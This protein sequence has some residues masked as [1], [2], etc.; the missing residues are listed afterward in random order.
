M[1]WAGAVSL[2]A[3]DEMTIVERLAH[4]HLSYIY[5]SGDLNKGGLD[6]SGFVQVVFREAYGL[7][8]PDEAD[9]QLGYCREHGQVWDAT[10]GWTPATLRP[11]DLIFFAGPDV[12]PR[13]SDV[14]HVMIYC[15]GNIMA[16]AQG[17]GI[18]MDKVS[19][20]V[21]LYY[22][23]PHYPGGVWG[24]AGDRFFGHRRVFAYGRLT[25]GQ[26]P[27]GLMV[28]EQKPAPAPKSAIAPTPTAAK[29]FGKSSRVD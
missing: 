8:L 20:G 21:G 17:K 19:G 1:A 26:T 7:E 11:G 15:G 4:Q 10:S 25:P 14:E 6:C 18:Q 13:S 23:R 24:E 27:T 22:F 12:L 28:A 5:G 9:K 2:R 29:P 3:G 16:G